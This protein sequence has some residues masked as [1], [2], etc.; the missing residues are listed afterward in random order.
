MF[1]NKKFAGIK[2][3][4]YVAPDGNDANPGTIS[5]PFLTLERARDAMRNS[6]IKTVYLRAGTYL[7]TQTLVLEE[8]D[9]G[10]TWQTYPLD[11]MNSA[12][13]EGEADGNKLT[14][15]INILGGR[16]ITIDG[17]TL[18]SFTSRAIGVHGGAAYMGHKTAEY[19]NACPNFIECGIASGN[20]ITNCIVEN[21]EMPPKRGSWDRA[22]IHVQGN[23]PYTTI[24]HNVI[25]NMT[26]YGIG[27]WSLQAG[28]NITGC[29]ISDNV[30]L[31]IGSTMED[32]GAIYTLDRRVQYGEDSTGIEIKNNF[33]R[34]YGTFEG[35]A[36][37]I[38]LDDSTSHTIISGNIISGT[39]TQP[40]LVHSGNSN[41]ITGNIFD[42]GSSG[43]MCIYFFVNDVATSTMY[44][45]TFTNNIILSS[46][47]KDNAYYGLSG[48]GAYI[49]G[50]KYVYNIKQKPVI[51][52]NFYHN[53]SVGGVRTYGINYQ[54]ITLEDSNPVTGDPK[55][56]GWYYQID[57]ASPVYESPVNF[58]PVVG[59]WGPAGYE[60]P[61][62]G[63]KPSCGL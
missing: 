13:I 47:E 30:I 9:S 59:G 21:G 3:V 36:R 17:L 38:Y 7:R 43:Q 12:V 22:G 26:G 14:D 35:Q 19:G 6:D 32:G 55:I 4:Y 2:K 37:A 52:D 20:T 49:I 5:E 28:D 48:T 46:Y 27:V 60:I 39:G 50:G 53:Y 42:L 56:F 31:N 8:A 1:Y 34:D 58:P 24:S 41:R 11:P 40:V 61:K 10:Q 33:I 16:D 44:G 51:R 54:G 25:Q 62:T 57:P 23:V 18:R 29:R 45:N 15:I 63:T